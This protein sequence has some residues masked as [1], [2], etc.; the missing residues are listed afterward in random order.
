MILCRLMGLA[1]AAWLVFGAANAMALT[2]LTTAAWNRYEDGFVN[3]QGDRGKDRTEGHGV[4][5]AVSRPSGRQRR[6][7]AIECGTISDLQQFVTGTIDWAG[8]GEKK[9]IRLIGA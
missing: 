4:P 9:N 6:R 5:A 8:K 2:W 7:R 1:A 3:R